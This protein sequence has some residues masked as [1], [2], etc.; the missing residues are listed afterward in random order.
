MAQDD[1][2]QSPPVAQEPVAQEPVAQEPVAQEPADNGDIIYLLP[3][4]RSPA[5]SC[6]VSWVRTFAL[7][8]YACVELLGV[9]GADICSP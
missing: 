2:A 1:L 4:S 6:L 8:D 5:W 3:L 9:L 7:P